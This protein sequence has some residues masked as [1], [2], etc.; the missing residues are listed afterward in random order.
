MIKTSLKRPLERETKDRRWERDEED[1]EGKE[2]KTAP[3]GKGMEKEEERDKAEEEADEEEAEEIE[4]EE[5]GEG[6]E[7]EKEK[8]M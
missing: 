1:S 2:I 5:E 7:E 4:E 8:M 6:E 3:V